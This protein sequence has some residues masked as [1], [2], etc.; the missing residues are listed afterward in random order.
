MDYKSINDYE[1]VYRIR[2]NN[3]DDAIEMMIKKY[4]PIICSYAK[5]YIKFASQHGVEFDD[6]MEFKN[7]KMKK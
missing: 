4:E 2:E 7:R 6:L 3:D 5:K 1:L